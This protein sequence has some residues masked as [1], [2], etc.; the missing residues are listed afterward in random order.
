MAETSGYMAWLGWSDGNIAWLRHDRP[1]RRQAR[2]KKAPMISLA[3]PLIPPLH[4]QPM[5]KSRVFDMISS[6]LD[7]EM[8]GPSLIP[9]SG[10]GLLRNGNSEWGGAFER[11]IGLCQVPPT[12]FRRFRQSIF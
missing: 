6:A 10:P 2:P 3:L 12:L 11:L 4:E 9:K 1:D 5:S 7:F 8:P